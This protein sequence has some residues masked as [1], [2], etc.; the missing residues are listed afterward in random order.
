MHREPF[1]YWRETDGTFLGYLNTYPDLWTQGDN[2]EDLKD[3]LLDLYREFAKGD[4]AWIRTVETW[5]RHVASC[6]GTAATG[7]PPPSGDQRN[8]GQEDSP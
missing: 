2:L 8:A 5:N 6:S 1:T 3:H 7:A 4:L